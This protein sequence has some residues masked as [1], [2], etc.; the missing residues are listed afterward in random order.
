MAASE[1]NFQ[2]T[3][4]FCNTENVSARVQPMYEIVVSDS[5]IFARFQRLDFRY[6]NLR[7]KVFVDAVHVDCEPVADD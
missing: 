4:A 6:T 1:N 5:K 7:S 3:S 2:Y